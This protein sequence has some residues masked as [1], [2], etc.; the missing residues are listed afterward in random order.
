MGIFLAKKEVLR[1]LL[2]AHLLGGI[3]HSHGKGEAGLARALV[4]KFVFYTQVGER[5][6]PMSINSI[7]TYLRAM[8]REVEEEIDEERATH[9]LRE[10]G[11]PK[12]H[13][14]H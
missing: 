11:L 12:K 6:K 4:T 9:K 8:K 7:I 14:S 3:T 5:H 2:K 10:K 1:A 13:N